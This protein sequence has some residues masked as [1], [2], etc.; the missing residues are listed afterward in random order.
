M[1]ILITGG[2]GMIGRNILES[3]L[4][5]NYN[6]LSPNSNEL[7]LTNF[8]KTI[9]Y[10]NGFKPDLIIHAAGRVGG[11]QANVNQPVNFL[12][13]NLDIGRNI[14]IAARQAGIKKLLNLGSSCMYPRNTLNPL[15]E[16][17]IL[18]GELE[19]S[20][21]GY[22]LAKIITTRL[23]DYI[24]R[25][26]PKF[27]YKTMIPCNIY[28]RF[29]NFD[30]EESHLIPAIINKLHQ[31]IKEEKKEVEIWG[32]GKARREFMYADDLA[33]A[34]S[35]A[36][37]HF[38]EMPSQINIGVGEDHTINEYYSIVASIMSFQGTFTHNLDK[39]TGM[40]Q[41]LVSIERQTAWGW[42]PKMNLHE[43][44]KLTYNYFLQEIES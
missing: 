43:G 2:S 14:I 12:V 31:A 34:I 9:K 11:I 40:L 16:E 44:L 42:K 17:M 3:L 28:G 22:A 29:D 6:I 24:H 27:Q 36:L 37:S 15:K 1:R 4:S 30:P 7:D 19:P 39:P 18:Q 20:N 26:N 8:N 23:C 35:Y 38:D 5:F 21:E 10:I 32:D 13:T 41:K 33:D 25:E